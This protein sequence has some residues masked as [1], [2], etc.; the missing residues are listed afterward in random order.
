V[1]AARARSRLTAPPARAAARKKARKA[2]AAPTAKARSCIA[3][4]FPP[5]SP[6]NVVTEAA[7]A[8][9][10]G[11]PGRPSLGGRCTESSPRVLRGIVADRLPPGL[12]YDPRAF[13]RLGPAMF[14][15][16]D[17]DSQRRTF[18]YVTIALIVL[19]VLVFLL[20]L[21]QGE[22]FIANW[23]FVPARFSQEPG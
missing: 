10:R 15:V 11:T 12:G 20:E 8:H 9:P 18:P 4:G 1:S 2:V 16:S 14:P 3:T 7:C 17:D 19:N 22:G 5:R 21:S 23:A 6:L 13:S